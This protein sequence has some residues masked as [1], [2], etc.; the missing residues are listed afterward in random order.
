MKENL[1]LLL[2][3]LM[4]FLTLFNL[5]VYII[6]YLSIYFSLFQVCVLLIEFYIIKT[7]SLDFK[8]LYYSI[9]IFIFSFNIN[10]IYYVLYPYLNDI[11][12]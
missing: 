4:L 7:N 5:I 12:E 2:A 1:K 11:E 8:Y 10:N 9:V 3:F 6:K